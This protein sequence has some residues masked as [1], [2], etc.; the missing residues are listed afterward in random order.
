[1]V[2]AC[3][4]W[5]PITASIYRSRGFAGPPGFAAAFESFLHA[6]A[7]KSVLRRHLAG[8]LADLPQFFVRKINFLFISCA[9][10]MPQTRLS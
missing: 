4:P 3:C 5:L 7:G 9:F 10:H 6:S 8:K 1:M 2:I